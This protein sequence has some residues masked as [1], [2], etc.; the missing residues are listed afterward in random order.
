MTSRVC[1]LG[2]VNCDARTEIFLSWSPDDSPLPFLSCESLR[3][4]ATCLAACL[5]HGK[6]EH[7][8]PAELEQPKMLIPDGIPQVPR[9]RLQTRWW[10]PS[11]M[12]LTVFRATAGPRDEAWKVRN[13]KCKDRELARRWGFGSHGRSQ[14]SVMRDPGR[15]PSHLKTTRKRER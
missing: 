5:K 8:L 1:L 12:E 11:R 13:R 14:R 2:E 9:K 7:E 15:D 6:L 3:F 4:L 10:V